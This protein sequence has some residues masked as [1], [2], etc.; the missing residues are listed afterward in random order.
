[1]INYP[2]QVDVTAEDI[3]QGE[4]E[5][6]Q[7][8]PIALAVMRATGSPFAVVQ[9]DTVTLSQERIVHAL[10]QKAIDFIGFFDGHGRRVVKPFSFEITGPIENGV[11]A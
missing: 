6:C 5:E 3:E 10:P 4:Q 7:R 2:I 9:E 11:P 8:C 1:M